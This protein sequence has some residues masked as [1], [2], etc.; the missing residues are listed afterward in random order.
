MIDLVSIGY[1]GKPYGKDGQLKLRVEDKYIDDLLK[2]NAVFIN[3][4]G[5]KVPFIHSKISVGSHILI[6]LDDIDNPQA[7]S[8][9]VSKE[10]LIESKFISAQPES[11]EA[12]VNDFIGFK[13][14]NQD[15]D[16]VGTISDVIQN[17]HQ[18]LLEINTVET[19]FLMPFH[20]DLVIDVD[21]MAGNIFLEIV[22]GLTSL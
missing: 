6:Q 9:L 8:E 13:V 15:K 18:V 3:L 16:Y 20:S 19:T 14:Y 17:P 4:D 11:E 22:D 1:T 10:I 2:S 5:S 7:A 12:S 21:P